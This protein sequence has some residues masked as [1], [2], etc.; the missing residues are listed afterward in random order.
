LQQVRHRLTLVDEDFVGERLHCDLVLEVVGQDVA[1]LVPP[2]LA[3][4]AGD[5]DDGLL[6]LVVSAIL[7]EKLA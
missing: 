6:F 3:D 1:I 5:L 2:A 7:R 4:P